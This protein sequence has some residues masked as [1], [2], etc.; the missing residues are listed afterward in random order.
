MFTTSTLN[1]LDPAEESDLKE[2]S[3]QSLRSS[4]ARRQTE[5]ATDIRKESLFNMVNTSGA[6]A[7]CRPLACGAH[8]LTHVCDVVPPSR[9]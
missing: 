4:I 8:A 5:F 6:C 3:V 2:G 7:L 9:L 1:K